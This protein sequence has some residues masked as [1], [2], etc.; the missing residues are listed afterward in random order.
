M[1]SNSHWRTN[2]VNE[3]S[4]VS[5]M[6]ANLETVGDERPLSVAGATALYW[7]TQESL[8]NVRR[9]AAASRADVTLNYEAMQIRL[10]VVDDGQGFDIF[11][12]ARGHGL[13]NVNR[14]TE[15]LDG[16]VTIESVP[17][18]GTSVTVTLPA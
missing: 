2:Q 13:E 15:E 9:L 3:F 11:S 1:N 18:E 14:R 6:E 8:A 17:G 5:G 7:L 12:V 16:S 10:N 4:R